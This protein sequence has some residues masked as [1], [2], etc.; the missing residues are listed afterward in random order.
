MARANRWAHWQDMLHFKARGFRWFDW[1]GLFSDEREP[2]HTNVNSFKRAFGGAPIENYECK[3][4]ITPRGRIALA[5]TA[6]LDRLKSWRT[7]P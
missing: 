1:G 3:V 6:L 2:D 4:P 5:V 7:D